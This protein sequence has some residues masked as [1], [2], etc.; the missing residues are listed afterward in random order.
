MSSTSRRRSERRR[1]E[2]MARSFDLSRSQSQQITNA[3]GG[4]PEA[5]SSFGCVLLSRYV[6]N[7]ESVET[8]QPVSMKIT[9]P[10]VQIL[11]LVVAAISPFC[12]GSPAS[13]SGR[14]PPCWMVVVLAVF[15]SPRT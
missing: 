12:S 7:C 11:M 5:E 3:R 14:R 4:S 1:P 15:C 9:P 6:H 10:A 2:A 13:S 8:L